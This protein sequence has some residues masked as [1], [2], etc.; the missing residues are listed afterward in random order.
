MKNTRIL[1]SCGAALLSTALLLTLAPASHAADL[2]YTVTLKTSSLVGNPDGPFSLDLELIAGSNNGTHGN[3]SNT[4]TLSNFVFAG[5]SVQASPNFTL[6]SES[7]SVGSSVV[8]TNSSLTNIYAIGFDT[9]PTQISFQVDETTNSEVVGTG[10]PIPDQFSVYLDNNNAST[11]FFVPTTD[12]SGNNTLVT[13]A[14]NSGMIINS[15]GF[16]NSVSPDGG[17]TTSVPEPGSAALLLFGAVGLVA[18]RKR[19]AA[20]QTA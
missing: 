8:L 7:G 2:I 15:V 11:G 16:S 12:P 9:F 20:A 17:V 14:I 19:S 13:S 18:R 3:V 10:T 6:G 5:G 1:R 4:V